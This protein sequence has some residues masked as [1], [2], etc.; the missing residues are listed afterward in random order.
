[1]QERGVDF[2]RTA[3]YYGRYRPV[4]PDAFFER[5]SAYGIGRK[6]QRILDLGEGTGS[7]AR[8]FSW[9]G[10]EVSGIDVSESMLEEARRLDRE[11]DVSITYPVAKAEETGLPNRS[12]DV[13]S[14]GQCWHWFDRPRAA[15]EAMRVLKPGGKLV[16]AHFDPIPLPGDVMEATVDLIRQHNSKSKVN[17][18]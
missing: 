3:E 10:C 16:I 14:A 4:F 7:L 1:M 15:E 2:G 13:V 17:A 6:G 18:K 11:A 9:R 5:L 8:G 12:F